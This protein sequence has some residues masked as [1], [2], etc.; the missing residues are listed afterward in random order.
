MN[1]NRF[2]NQADNRNEE[3]V[4]LSELFNNIDEFLQ[5]T[6]S[7]KI[8]E[9]QSSGIAS[10]T[11]ADADVRCLSIGD[12]VDTT[13][14]KKRSFQNRKPIPH[15]DSKGDDGC[16][17]KCQARIVADH[18]NYD[19]LTV[20]SSLGN[21][22]PSADLVKMKS[23]KNKKNESSI[24]NVQ[25]LLANVLNNKVLFPQRLH[26]ILESATENGY[27]DIISWLKHGRSFR[28]NDRE[29]FIRSIMSQ[30]FNQTRYSS[31]LRQLA[32]YGFLRLNNKNSESFGSYYHEQF[33]RGYPDLVYIIQRTAVKGKGSRKFALPR[34]EPDF[35]A[36]KPVGT[37]SIAELNSASNQPTCIAQNTGV[38]EHHIKQNSVDIKSEE[39]CKIPAKT[40]SEVNLTSNL[41]STEKYRFG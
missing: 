38:T 29:R 41:D 40:K 9:Y 12:R 28:V 21:A 26:L 7:E 10:E 32:L 34:I 39:Y 1:D 8:T 15:S 36:M 19:D 11:S 27:D 16:E 24:S 25:V 33:L 17:K 14:Q 4:M 23:L 31:F 5:N 18:I 13:L 6:A 22:L 3:E 37:D 20:S 35:E 30:F 2:G